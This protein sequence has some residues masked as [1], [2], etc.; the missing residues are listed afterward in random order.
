MPARPARLVVASTLALA[1]LLAGCGGAPP[2]S[3]DE[4][5]DLVAGTSGDHEPPSSAEELAS[6]SDVVVRGTVEDVTPGRVWASSED[7]PAR[8]ETVTVVV[9]V[10]EVEQGALP[11]GHDGHLYLEASF[12]G[13]AE[14]GVDAV[15]RGLRV[16]VYAWLL[17]DETGEPILDPAAGRP[18]GQHL[19]VVTTPE[20]WV[21]DP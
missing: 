1:A 8:S 10:D 11:A 4:F 7:D 12:H 19:H 15:P 17:P 13:G 3:A 9:A 2:V 6:W 20:G 5:T 18:A 21:V 14:A 16:Q